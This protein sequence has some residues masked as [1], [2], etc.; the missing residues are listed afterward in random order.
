MD[1]DLKP[2][3]M[4]W[5]RRLLI[6]LPRTMV[7]RSII[8]YKVVEVYVSNRFRRCEIINIC[9]TCG[10]LLGD[11]SQ[12]WHCPCTL[13]THSLALTGSDRQSFFPQFG[14]E[15][16]T[17]RGMFPFWCLRGFSPPPSPNLPHFPP[18]S[19]LKERSAQ[20]GI[21]ELSL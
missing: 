8:E 10:R 7:Y 13:P 5:Q 15:I 21:R 4:S 1:Y 16:L 2:A 6:W 19:P 12:P 20:K 17:Y 3:I 18:G 14:V 11:E 9:S